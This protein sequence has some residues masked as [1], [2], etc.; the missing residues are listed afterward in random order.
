[1][2]QLHINWGGGGREKGGKK[3][4]EEKCNELNMEMNNTLKYNLFCVVLVF[5]SIYFMLS[6]MIDLQ[7]HTDLCVVNVELF[8]R[9]YLEE[10]WRLSHGRRE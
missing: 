4:K 8:C 3:K 6:R 2:L 7:G 5:N 9:D 10:S 1:M